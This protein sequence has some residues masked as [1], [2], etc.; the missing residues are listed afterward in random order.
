MRQGRSRQRESLESAYYF[1][2]VLAIDSLI[3][4]TASACAMSA[5]SAAE[6][7]EARPSDTCQPLIRAV[8]EKGVTSLTTRGGRRG[9]RRRAKASTSVSQSAPS[10]MSIGFSLCKADR[11]ANAVSVQFQLGE[12]PSTRFR[13]RG[14]RFAAKM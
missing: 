8:T 10:T 13:I 11:A 9:D 4:T 6:K 1:S 2:T 7:R 14:S 3:G 12:K 5:R